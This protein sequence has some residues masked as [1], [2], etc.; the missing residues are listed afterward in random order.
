MTIVEPFKTSPLRTRQVRQ[1]KS[2]LMA[3]KNWALVTFAEASAARAAEAV[4]VVLAAG[5]ACH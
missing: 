3:P 4:E 5:R 2:V 1:K